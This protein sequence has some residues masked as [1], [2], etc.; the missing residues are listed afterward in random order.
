[1][2]IFSADWTTFLIAGLG[3][4]FLI[5]EI[6]VSARGVFGILGVILISMYFYVYLETGSFV[7]MF[8]IYLAGLFLIII[9]GKFLNDGTLAT[10]GLIGMLT[11]VALSAPS[12]NAGLYAVCGVLLGGGASFIL[13]KVFKGR[14]MWSKITLKDRLTTEAGYNSM[15]AQYEAL[16]GEKGVTLTDLR[17][18]GI[19]RIKH[20][21]YSAVSDGQWIPKHCKVHVMQVDGTK[22]SVKKL[23]CE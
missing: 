9:D 18:V 23:N 2:T 22:I 11:A 16:I 13:L 10:L 6:L 21:K 8:I 20:Q 14:N 4:F 15:N 19:V 7:L 12:I 5:G 17:P 1:M 3:T